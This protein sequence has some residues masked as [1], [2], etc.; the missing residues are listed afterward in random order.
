M[1]LGAAA[2]SLLALSITLLIAGVGCRAGQQAS[3]KDSTQPMAGDDEKDVLYLTSRETIQGKLVGWDRNTHHIQEDGRPGVTEIPTSS[4]VR[5]YLSPA[6]RERLAASAEDPAA[7]AA[8][9]S[10][11]SRWF[12][13]PGGPA[14]ETP[15]LIDW[16][17]A[18]SPEECAGKLLPSFRKRPDFFLFLPPGGSLVLTETR[19]SL[20]HI[21]G[22]PSGIYLPEPGQPSLK[23]SIPEA[24]KDLPEGYLLTSTAA[25]LKGPEVD[26]KRTF[27][28]S[29]HISVGVRP[30]SARAM[31][32]SQPFAG[33]PIK[34]SLG[35]GSFFAIGKDA[36]SFFVYILDD[37]K[38]SHAKVLPK[39]FAAYQDVVLQA[40]WT[41]DIKLPDGNTIGRVLNVPYPPQLPSDSKAA[42]TIYSGDPEKS[43][44][45]LAA[46]NL[47]PRAS[48][49][50]PP[51]PPKTKAEVWVHAHD[52]VKEIP[53][54]LFVSYGTGLP[55]DGATVLEYPDLLAKSAIDQKVTIDFADTK[56]EEDYPFPVWLWVRRVAH[57]KTTGGRLEI[58]PSTAVANPQPIKLRRTAV[59]SGLSHLIPLSFQGP[60]PPTAQAQSGTD[61]AVAAMGSGFLNGLA[62][63]A[64]AM[65][66]GGNPTSFTNNVGQ[67]LPGGGTGASGTPVENSLT[68]NVTVP[69]PSGS[70]GSVSGMESVGGSAQPGVFMS[71]TPGYNGGP[72]PN[73]WGLGAYGPVGTAVGNQ[74]Y[75]YQGRPVND[76][77][78]S[79]Q[80]WLNQQQQGGGSSTADMS[81]RLPGGLNYPVRRSR[82]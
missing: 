40:A 76:G 33:A 18:H 63:D 21:H 42:I 59:V 55:K 57:W 61:P 74:R 44:T 79:A 70:F 58:L 29:D 45:V 35:E 24:E 5:R 19:S 20:F 28:P 72:T 62:R 12:R 11:A 64:M 23:L 30:L 53:E 46:V 47:P 32:L 75:D 2:R 73:P 65:E 60:K 80:S 50:L 27:I 1:A 10:R 37:E 48:L 78:A 54:D 34:T 67:G 26:P 15:G 43:P 6:S 41:L 16:T 56:K 82:P 13:T 17:Y 52:A 51:K 71:R 8:A 68:V 9:P 25:E 39:T 14:N 66:A 49:V 4:V 69:P 31:L 77:S 81:V 38:G 22:F 7:A 36:Q 3:W